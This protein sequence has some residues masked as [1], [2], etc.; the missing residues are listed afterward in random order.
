LTAR[1]L[2]LSNYAWGNTLCFYRKSIL[3]K[4]GI[5]PPLDQDWDDFVNASKD[6]EGQRLLR[7]GRTSTALTALWFRMGQNACPSG[8]QRTLLPGR[9]KRTVYADNI[10][11]NSDANVWAALASGRIILLK[12][13]YGKRPRTRRIPGNISGTAIPAAFCYDGPWFVGMC[14]ANDPSM[15]DDIGIIPSPNVIYNVKGI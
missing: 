4:V 5:D 12:N 1:T 7:H 15:M 10:Q 6:P 13:G 3:E 14:E 2:A 11:V 9:G 8:F